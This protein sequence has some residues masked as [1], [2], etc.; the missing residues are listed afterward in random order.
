MT[1][2]NERMQSITLGIQRKEIKAEEVVQKTKRSVMDAIEKNAENELIKFRK[3]QEKRN[4][5]KNDLEIVKYRQ[6]IHQILLARNLEETKKARRNKS[7]SPPRALLT[8]H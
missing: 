1:W 3:A 7:K 8:Y 2:L 4:A 5:S 6:Q